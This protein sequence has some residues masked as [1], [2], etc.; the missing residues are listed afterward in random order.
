MQRLEIIGKFFLALTATVAIFVSGIIIPPAGLVLF[1]FVPQPIL[2]FGL[3]YGVVGGT[4]VALVALA[5]LFFLGGKEFAFIYGLLASVAGFLLLLLGRIR[6]VEGLVLGIASIIFAGTVVLLSHLYGSWS[7]LLQAVRGYITDHIVAGVQVYEKM[8]FPKE[9]LDLLKERAPQIAE[10]IL[11]LLP[12][13]VFVA[14][15]LIVLFNVV[16]LCRRFPERRG[17]WLSVESLRE[18]KAPDSIVWGLIVC[19]FVMFIPGFDAAK[20]VAANMLLVIV[21]S[22]FFQG[23]AIV[24]YFFHKNNVPRFFRAVIYLFIVFQ[25][26]CTLL[27]AGLGLFDLWGDFRR[28]KNKD[29]KPS[30]AS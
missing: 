21:A 5:S 30:Q 17:Q 24:A 13:L 10:T 22:Y 16:V 6:A 18:W 15:A 11:Q 26:V 25:Q 23:L 28:L 4:G 19:G 12:A 3:K 1:P 20:L 7:A 14:L 29:L 27:V 9:S 8:D 2:W